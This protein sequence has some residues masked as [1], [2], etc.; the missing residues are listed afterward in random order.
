MQCLRPCPIQHT[1]LPQLSARATMSTVEIP[2]P[3]VGVVDPSSAGVAASVTMGANAAAATTMTSSSRDGQT[4][5]GPP[6]PT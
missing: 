6:A 3:V 1:H 5:S 4:T 2:A